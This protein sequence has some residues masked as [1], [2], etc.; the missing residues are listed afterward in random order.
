MKELLYHPAGMILYALIAFLTPLYFYSRRY[1]RRRLYYMPQILK[2]KNTPLCRFLLWAFGGKDGQMRIYR[3]GRMANIIGLFLA[4]I[5]LG[6]AFLMGWYKSISF[7]KVYYFCL[8]G[9]TLFSGGM[10]AILID[11]NNLII[12]REKRRRNLES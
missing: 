5:L 2:E 11:I 9:W 4:L 1:P 12:K 8:S 7:I 3:Y 6:I 10:P